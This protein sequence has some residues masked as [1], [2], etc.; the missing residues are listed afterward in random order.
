MLPVESHG[1]CFIIILIILPFQRTPHS[2][3]SPVKIWTSLCFT[4]PSP[5]STSIQR[6]LNDSHHLTLINIHSHL[7]LPP[8][9]SAFVRQPLTFLLVSRPVWLFPPAFSLSNTPP[10]SPLPPHPHPLSPD[11]CF[12]LMNQC[13][14]ALM[15][16][17]LR[18]HTRWELMCLICQCIKKR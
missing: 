12:G 7:P 5:R 18:T 3:S 14:P 8:L 17:S 6:H 11:V 4:P 10:L 13:L 15:F 1:C 9:F 16:L 2:S